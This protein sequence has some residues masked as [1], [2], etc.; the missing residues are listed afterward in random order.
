MRIKKYNQFIKENL[1]QESIGEWIESVAKD[2]DYLLNIISQYTQDVDPTVRLS[3][4]INVLDQS[5]Q[6]EIRKRVQDHL[7]GVEEPKD[8]D[9]SANVDAGE[10]MESAQISGK[11]VFKSFLKAITAL[12]LK[13][14]KPDWNNTPESFLIYFLFENVDVAK[15]KVILNRFKSLSMYIDSID[16]TQNICHLYFGIKT[17]MTFEY[18]FK[19]DRKSVV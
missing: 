2:D 12:G 13:E 18:G 14:H 4:A 8:V 9:V 15:L 5:Q 19:T 6:E 16:Y 17:D 10:L 7:D 1:S 11:N 3:N